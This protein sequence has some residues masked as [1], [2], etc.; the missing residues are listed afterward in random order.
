LKAI[1]NGF[2]IYMNIES[3]QSTWDILKTNENV[4]TARESLGTND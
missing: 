1:E 4:E 2:H 3:L